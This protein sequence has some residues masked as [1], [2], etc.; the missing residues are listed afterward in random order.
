MP[1]HY[2]FTAH[3]EPVDEEN[4]TSIHMDSYRGAGSQQQNTDGITH[5]RTTM[6][7]MIP[8]LFRMLGSWISHN[9][10]FSGCL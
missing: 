3:L 4:Y 6:E 1:L 10:T 5:A 7:L 2:I 8:Y 9:C